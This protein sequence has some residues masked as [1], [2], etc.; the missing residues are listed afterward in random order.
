MNIEK[1]YDY[2]KKQLREIDSSVR[3]LQKRLDE[4]HVFD[5]KPSDTN[6]VFFGCWIGLEDEEG[7]THN[8]RIVGPDEFDLSQG[9]LS[10]DSP[11]GRALL[12]KIAGDTVHLKTPEGETEWYIHSIT[13]E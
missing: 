7:R 6:R 4:L 3:F 10:C 13:Y 11:L 5:T 12:G 2:G 9:L 1:Q 8:Y